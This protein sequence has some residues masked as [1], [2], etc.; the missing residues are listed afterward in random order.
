MALFNWSK[1]K[2]SANEKPMISNEM[3]ML[4]A[5]L[6]FT[7]EPTWDDAVLEQ[8]I[9]R[10]FPLFSSTDIG[11]KENQRSRQYFF[12]DYIVRYGE[13]DLPAQGTIFKPEKEFSQQTL[14]SAYRQAWHWHN[15]EATA[16]TCKYDLMV[17]DLMSMLLTHQD[18]VEYYQKFLTAVV[19]ALKPTAIYFPASEKLIEPEEYLK[20]IE[21]H[22]FR[23]LYALI[24]VRLFNVEGKGMLMD[25]LGL[26]ALGLPDFQIQFLQY[27]P[28]QIAGLLYSYAEYIFNHGSVIEDGNTVEGVEQGSRWRCIYSRAAIPP[29]RSVIEIKPE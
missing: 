17:G 1:K 27:D 24:N 20:Q 22:G 23:N 13:G 3:Q 4:F 18:R 8:E 29:N 25:S 21:E 7:S 26:Q 11:S 19:K 28:G 10:N 15:A 14:A 9:V 12:R 6:L 16:G 2:E 5:K